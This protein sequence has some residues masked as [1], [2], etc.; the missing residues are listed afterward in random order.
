M[1]L[2]TKLEAVNQMLQMIGTSPV[3][4]LSGSTSADVATAK[5][6]L[7]EASREIQS[8]GWHFNREYLVE[9]TPDTEKFIY[10]PSNVLRIDVEPANAQA[11]ITAAGDYIDVVQRGNRLYDKKDH[12][13]EFEAA[14]K[15]T[16]VYGLEWDELPQ[17]VRTFV[18]SRAGRVFGDRM[19]GAGEQHKFNMLAEGQAM[20][21]ARNWDAEM[22]D[23][24]I[25]DSWSTYRII[26]RH[27]QPNS[28]FG[29]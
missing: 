11:S 10:L 5:A 9:L 24:S 18:A 22:A 15:A 2:T 4:T 23:N 3:S 26:N 20:V 1:N 14:V 13:F 27:G 8:S 29:P 16:I 21:A 28:V 12:T 6:V 25:F 7:D 17:P 19:I